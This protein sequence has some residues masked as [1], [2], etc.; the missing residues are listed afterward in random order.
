MKK[1]WVLTGIVAATLVVSGGTLAG[2]GPGPG[3]AGHGTSNTAAVIDT[4]IQLTEQEQADLLFMREEEKL[5][6]D[7][8]ARLYQRWGADVFT[9][10]SG[11]EQRHMDSVKTLL[12]AYG[13]ADPAPAAA[14]RFTNTDLQVLY[15]QLV[16]RGEASLIEAL[17]VGTL[18]E[19]VD[20]DDLHGAIADTTN[21]AIINVY[22][23][24][25]NGSYRHLNAFTRQLA[26]QDVEYEPQVLTDEAVDAI[27]SGETFSADLSDAEAVDPAGQ[28]MQTG[29][30]FSYSIGLDSGAGKNGFRVTGNER[31]RLSSRLLPDAG[32][33]GR[34]ADDLIVARYHG[35]DGTQASYARSGN[36]WVE[37]DGELATLTR[38]GSRVLEEGGTME[39]FDGP[40]G[41][42]RGRFEIFVGYRL[43]NG[44]MVYSSEP[45]TFD[46]E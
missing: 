34:Q 7:V 35:V 40:L 21:P 19:E 10:I 20:I 17:K 24:L 26:A 32:D 1:K 44:K 14:G 43:A 4:G 27:L 46:V 42:L 12:D 45:I 18:I 6:R 39:I 11:A 2:R 36:R 33:V 22:T 8:Y 16:A 9:N 25:L 37:W 3:G 29:S 30:R 41:D 15:D 28:Q 38:A 13:L 31:V 23:N 5:A